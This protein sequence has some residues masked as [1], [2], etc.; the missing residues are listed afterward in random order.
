[1]NRL[2]LGTC[3][4]TG[5]TGTFGQA[6]ARRVLDDNLVDR[7]VVYSRDE[8]KQARMEAELADPR[9]R[10]F[11]GDVRDREQLRRAFRGVDT[12]VH[13]AAYKQ[14]QRS[15]L[16]ILE[17]VGVNVGGTV[18]VTQA[19]H[20]CD[21]KKVVFLSSDKACSSATPYGATKSI[22]EWI[23]INSNV[24]GSAR[25]ITTRYGNVLGSRGSVIE[26]W[27]RQIEE[28]QLPKITNP[29]MT[30]FWITIE[31]AVE[32]VLLA[33]ERGRGGEVFIPKGI[34][35]G[36]IVDLLHEYHS[37]S[38]YE[39]IG[40]RAYEKTAEELISAEEADRVVDC[41]DVYVLLPYLGLV[42][43]HPLP[44]GVLEGEGKPVPARFSYRSDA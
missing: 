39:V 44:Y 42:R 32:L 2:A 33:L 22:G 35:R 20:D 11:L 16:D 14:V 8:L 36:K 37:G 41:G 30:R 34:R 17:F 19:A 5:G 7:L 12:V 21:V 6:F 13:A 26:L 31:D 18:N 40:K 10:F 38:D 9:L 28:G 1:M 4:V 27:R 24:Y 43:W 15:A 25:I 3:L 29:N 23:A